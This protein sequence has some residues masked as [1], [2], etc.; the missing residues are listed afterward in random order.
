[1]KSKI[2]HYKIFLLLIIVFGCSPERDA[3][4]C[5]T[6]VNLINNSDK[7]IY[8]YTGSSAMTDYNPLKSGEYF[9]IALG[10]TKKDG[11]GRKGCYEERFTENNNKFYYVFYDEQVLLNNTWED[12]VANDLVLKR[13]SFTLQEMEAADWTI[14]YTGN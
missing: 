4:N 2:K 3:A 14:N 1:M 13:Y 7:V 5:H 6:S 12:V 8:F 11:F 10:D 9:K